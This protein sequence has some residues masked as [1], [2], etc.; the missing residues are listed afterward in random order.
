MNFRNVFSS[1]VAPKDGR[2]AEHD[3]LEERY[4]GSCLASPFCLINK[5]LAHGIYSV[6][7][8]HDDLALLG[9]VSFITSD[10]L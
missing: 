1:G 3:Y 6:G 10:I 2:A 9:G 5:Y 7:S 8:V 4:E